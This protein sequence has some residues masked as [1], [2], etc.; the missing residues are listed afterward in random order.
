MTYKINQASKM[1]NMDL[2]VLDNRIQVRLA[3]LL[4]E[5]F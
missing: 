1:L 2:G 3:F 5:M 4:H